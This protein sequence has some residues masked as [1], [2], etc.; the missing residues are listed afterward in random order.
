[1]RARRIAKI[2]LFC[3]ISLFIL[4]YAVFQ[5]RKIIEGPLVNIT[6]PTDGQIVEQSEIIITGEAQNIAFLYL[7]NKKIFTD[8]EGIFRETTIV[9]M[10]TNVLELKAD[11]KFGNEIIR[12]VTVF[13]NK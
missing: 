9:A 8:D 3:C 12:R 10:G 1:M 7:N 6:S 13:R 4:G 11:D 2:I 5:A